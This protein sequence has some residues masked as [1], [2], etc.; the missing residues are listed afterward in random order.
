MV[1]NYSNHAEQRCAERSIS[2]D[3]V[4]ET[5]ISPDKEYSKPN[6]RLVR[7]K[8]VGDRNIRVVYAHISEEEIFVITVVAL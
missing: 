2:E 4:K 7:E 5:I 6:G 8:K 3:E 1:I